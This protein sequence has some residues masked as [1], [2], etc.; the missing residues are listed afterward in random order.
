M[1]VGFIRG[2]LVELHH[3]VAVEPGLDLHAHFGRH[4]QLVAVDG[5][6]KRHAFFGD[7]AH[8][9]QA[10]HLK[11]ARV[12][13]DGF[14]PL[15]EAVQA[16]EA[17]HHVLAGAHPQVEGVAQ[18]DLGA[19]VVQALG[20]DALD[21]AVGAHG[22]EDGGFDHA[23]VERETTAAGVAF[24]LEQFKLEHG[25][26]CRRAPAGL[27]LDQG[28]YCT[29]ATL[30]L[31]TAC[32][33][34]WLDCSRVAPAP[35]HQHGHGQRQQQSQPQVAPT[36]RSNQSPQRKQIQ[37]PIVGAPGTRSALGP[38]EGVTNPC[39]A[40]LLPA[41]VVLFQ[42]WRRQMPLGQRLAAGAAWR[43]HS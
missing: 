42:H 18:D 34:P 22:H 32:S 9:A 11:A 2:A 37:R 1:A 36:S 17:F 8:G 28:V 10:P 35:G 15:L 16:A 27:A 43:R 19:H 29:G 24:G 26:H 21:R 20:H 25:R 3:D 33:V 7:L 38:S 41:G 13:E 23:V 6:G 39:A 5:A 12:G 40:D 14:V 30:S 31:T 4:E